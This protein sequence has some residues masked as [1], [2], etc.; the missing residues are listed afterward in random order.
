M[1]NQGFMH[2]IKNTC[3]KE[4]TWKWMKNLFYRENN[5]YMSRNLILVY[6]SMCTFEY[7]KSQIFSRGAGLP[8]NN[9]FSSFKSRWQTC[10]INFTERSL[11]NQ[12]SFFLADCS[13]KIE[14]LNYHWMTVANS[15]DKL[16]KKETSLCREK[17]MSK[18]G[19]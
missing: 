7:P 4:G 17:N 6:Q 3:H 11:R 1:H 13:I 19:T 16:L 9:V 15:R 5:M 18:P 14:N 10:F 12:F 2:F 8:S